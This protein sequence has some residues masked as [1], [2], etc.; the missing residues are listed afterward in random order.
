MS[1]IRFHG[2]YEESVIERLYFKSKD[3]EY[4]S[5]VVVP[6]NSFVFMVGKNGMAM[7]VMT[8][9]SFNPAPKRHLFQKKERFDPNSYVF[10]SVNCGCQ[11]SKNPLYGT[12]NYID[13][14]GADSDVQE[15]VK[16]NVSYEYRF[17]ENYEPQILNM[18]SSED[19][20]IYSLDFIEGKIAPMIKGIIE[21]DLSRAL[22][23]YKIGSINAHIAEISKQCLD[24]I[25]RSSQN[26]KSFGIEILS[27]SIDL[28]KEDYEHKAVKQAVQEKTFE[29]KALASVK[30][31]KKDKD[32]N[33][34]EN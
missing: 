6:P 27:V 16:Y 25:K 21:S 18:I 32:P 11:N 26:P 12:V 15:D 23:L 3:L 34:G 9:V 17:A 24:D 5:T 33:D 13:N 20:R 30:K 28:I 8:S 2:S 7:P 29:K 22:N 4:N 10:Y 14:P 19:R 1:E 31:A